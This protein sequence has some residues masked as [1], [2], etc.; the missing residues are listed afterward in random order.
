MAYVYIL[1]LAT[2]CVCDIQFNTPYDNIHLCHGHNQSMHMFSFVMYS[3]HPFLRSCCSGVAQSEA[4]TGSTWEELHTSLSG[5]RGTLSWSNVCSSRHWKSQTWAGLAP[6][7]QPIWSSV[8]CFLLVQPYCGHHILPTA[9][10]IH[11]EMYSKEH[12]CQP[13]WRGNL[14][15]QHVEYQDHYSPLI[16]SV[17]RGILEH[18]C[19][20]HLTTL[21]PLYQIFYLCAWE[22]EGAEQIQWFAW[23]VHMQF[24]L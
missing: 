14:Q 15:V 4:H 12:D 6:L 3:P 2:V 18:C 8:W 9:S 13:S 16:N 24:M 11:S 1:I 19:S 22:L 5:G 10:W 7:F 17:L 21:Q 20:F 23:V